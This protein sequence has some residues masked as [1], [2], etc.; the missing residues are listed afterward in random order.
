MIRLLIP[1]VWLFAGVAMA[2][3][4]VADSLPAPVQ[5][6]SAWVTSGTQTVTVGSIPQYA[7]VT[8]VR[9]YVNTVFNGS[10][11]N[12]IQVGYTGA[13]AALAGNTT[14]SD[15]STGWVTL[16]AGTYCTSWAAP[17]VCP[18]LD[19]SRVIVAKHI[20]GGTEPTTGKALVIV[21][22]QPAP[23]TP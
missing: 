5:Y 18:P 1:S 15:G 17:N 4:L 14:M 3:P 9:V 2:G 20:K 7:V 11:A 6:A 8:M 13:D 10:V 22:Y 23:A 19:T 12:T 16:T 21:E